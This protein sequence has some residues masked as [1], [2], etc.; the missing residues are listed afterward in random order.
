MAAIG[1]YVD[2]QLL[3]QGGM[4]AVYRGRDPELDRPVA[5]KVMLH[6]TPDFVQRF[7]REAQSIA[8]L[9]HA[10]IVQVYD[11]GV[12][13]DGNPYFVME[14]IDGTPL[15]ELIRKRGKLPPLE[16]VRLAKQAAAG[17]AAAHRAGIV[18]RDIKPS[19]LI[20]DGRGHLK[21]VDFGIA[22]MESGAQ[23]TNAAAL[24]GTPGYMAPEQASGKKVD[25]RADIYA[26][27]MTLFELLA[28][29]PAFTSDDPIAL[30]VM[31]IQNPLPDLR[32][33]APGT[34]EELVQLVEMMVRKD[35][36]ERLQSCDAV[37]AALEDIE[38]RLRTGTASYEKRTDQAAAAIPATNVHASRPPAVDAAVAAGL[39]NFSIPEKGA[40]KSKTSLAIGVGVGAVVLLGG[41]GLVVMMQHK[42]PV[43]KPTVVVTPEPQKTQPKPADTTIENQMKL[44][45]TSKPAAKEDGPLRV[46]V[47]K[48]KNVGGDKGL[49][50]LE[51]GIGETAVST[52][53]TAGGAVT[54]IE[55]SDIES[56][57]GELD[58]AKDEHFDK[59]TIAEKGKLEGVQMAVQ[60]GFQR[61]GK[62]VR[63]TARFVRVANGEIVD[64]LTVTRPARDVFGAQDEVARGLKQKLVALAALEKTKK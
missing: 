32:V 64:T 4:G 31:N 22:R 16:V 59:A 37:V 46:A 13:G 58:R 34:P 19:N 53:S 9:A 49:T 48:F 43:E 14:L 44:P 30:V 18:H 12:D 50:G 7:R 61:A 26:L 29:G 45:S 41:I 47:L 33:F 27:G 20:V 55:R 60:G 21:L 1:R 5:I 17:L 51:L 63:I 35:P 3:G 23:L 8:R 62:L 11:F 25:A 57:I 15:D 52:M 42:P 54:L 24:M 10:N 6:A 2:L 39:Q 56:D 40:A 36:D 28:G 38:A